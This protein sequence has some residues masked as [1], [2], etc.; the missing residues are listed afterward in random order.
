MGNEESRIAKEEEE[1][2]LRCL[3][4]KFDK[5]Q[6][7]RGGVRQDA[8]ELGRLLEWYDKK[9]HVVGAMVL[10]VGCENHQV[11]MFMDELY[12]LAPKNKTPIV[13]YEQQ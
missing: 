6:G 9:P 5:I 11:E 1:S 3:H 7:V 2:C 4:E 10:R 13:S 12:C 8:G